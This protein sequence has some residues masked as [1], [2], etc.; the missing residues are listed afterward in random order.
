MAEDCGLKKILASIITLAL[1]L[2]I[3]GC[4]GNPAKEVG[5]DPIDTAKKICEAIKNLDPEAID[6]CIDGGGGVAAVV[7]DIGSIEA[8]F[9]EVMRDEAATVHYIIGSPTVDGDS[10]TVP[11]LFEYTDATQS[12]TAVM[13]AYVESIWELLNGPGDIMNAVQEQE[14]TLFSKALEENWDTVENTRKVIDVDLP[15]VMKNGEWIMS[16]LPSSLVPVITANIGT[17]ID[18]YM[19]WDDTTGSTAPDR[20]QDDWRDH[21]YCDWTEHGLKEKKASV[22][23]DLV[24]SGS[25][26]KV[27]GFQSLKN[28]ENVDEEIIA[29]DGAKFLVFDYAITNT[30]SNTINFSSDMLFACNDK[31][32]LYEAFDMDYLFADNYLWETPIAP[33]ATENASVIFYVPDSIEDAGYYLAVTDLDKTVYKVYGQ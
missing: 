9:V 19:G 16:A 5:P 18:A 21:R 7:E 33:G 24:F 4:G 17:A 1:C 10:A 11:V 28:L 14:D 12:V 6:A 30:G 26:L 27:T 15:L 22:G 23:E 13:D 32:W 31:G 29:A 3:A 2:G 8:G 20:W 25:I